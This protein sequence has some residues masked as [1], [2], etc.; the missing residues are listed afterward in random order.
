MPV[1]RYRVLDGEGRPVGT[2]DFRCAPGPAGWRYFADI[3]TSDP[4]PHRERVDFV[5]DGNWRPV[6]LDVQTG[7]HSLTLR[8]SG[9]SLV[10]ERDGRA[11]E[12]PFGPET[13]IDYL[14]PSFNAVTVNRLGGSR[15][16][17]VVYLEPVTCEPSTMR[18]RYDLLEPKETV[19]TPVG[20]FEAVRWRY[21]SLQGGWTGELWVA[22]EVV[23][24]FE[25]LFELEA[26][27]PGS[28]GPFPA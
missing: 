25:R 18:Q 3:E 27:D 10:G 22:G 8:S 16:I 9:E 2:E 11:L 17:E 21:T 23:V 19:R 5:V 15:D 13:E 12:I 28:G 6:R 4:E 7:S 26:Y 1:G 20:E 24:A 14:S